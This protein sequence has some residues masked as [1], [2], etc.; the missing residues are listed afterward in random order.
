MEKELIL[1]SHGI[2]AKGLS[3]S[4]YKDIYRTKY[5]LAYLISLAI[6]KNNVF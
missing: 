6:S 2:M 5:N 1:I 4:I 3:D